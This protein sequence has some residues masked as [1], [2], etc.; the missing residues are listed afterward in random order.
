MDEPKRRSRAKISLLSFLLVF[1]LVGVVFSH[2]HTSKK[3][4]SLAQEV[5]KLRNEAGYISVEDE[6]QLH[7]ISLDTGE[8]NTWKWRLFLP[9]G[10]RYKWNIACEN[11]PASTPPA[12]PG[13][14]S[15]SNEPYWESETNVLVTAKL[16]EKSNGDWTMIVSS[17]IGDSNDQMGGSTLTIP[18]EKIRWLA[19]EGSTE[20]RLLGSRGTVT[21]DPQGP[22][23]L[24]QR[25]PCEKQP[26][27]GYQPSKG[28]MPGYV[29]WLSEM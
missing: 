18:A 28:P 8:A 20:V 10:R 13:V 3:L 6:S 21:R 29:I 15:V 16:R 9:K 7:A 14:S 17:K 22:I 25:R 23:I 27:G 4:H 2:W 19:T 1:S 24:L 26:N 11:I 5:N 12:K